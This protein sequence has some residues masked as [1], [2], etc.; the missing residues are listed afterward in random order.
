P[1]LAAVAAGELE[2]ARLGE[3][4]PVHI[5]EEGRRGLVIADEIARIDVAVAD[6]VLERNAPLPARLARGRTRVRGEWRSV[7][8]R[9]RDG[10]VARQPFGP[11][12]VSRVQRLLDQQPGKAAAVD[13][14][15]GLE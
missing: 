4:F 5:G 1:K 12:L 14:Q 9:R 13:E 11:I 8:A 6:A 10:A 15:I 7:L 2:H 3:R